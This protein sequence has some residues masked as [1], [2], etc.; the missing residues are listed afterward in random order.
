MFEVVRFD[1]KTKLT[2]AA[3]TPV[4]RIMMLSLLL[5]LFVA[6][7]VDVVF[8]DRLQEE[9]NFWIQQLD[10]MVDKYL[11]VANAAQSNGDIHLYKDYVKASR[12]SYYHIVDVNFTSPSVASSRIGGSSHVHKGSSS[13][14]NVDEED[15]QKHNILL[16]LQKVSFF[17]CVGVWGVGVVT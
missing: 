13:Q 12:K 6:V 17:K 7:F 11:T 9:K 14:N 1:N 4:S 16:E 10:S 8:F 5:M 15:A 3:S 2:L